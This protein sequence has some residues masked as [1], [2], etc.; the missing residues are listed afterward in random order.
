[1]EG[2]SASQHWHPQLNEVLEAYVTEAEVNHHVRLDLGRHS[3][4]EG[5]MTR[6]QYCYI[7]YAY[8]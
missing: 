6:Y 3:I 2:Q 8:Q 4:Q 7:L 5:G 1:M